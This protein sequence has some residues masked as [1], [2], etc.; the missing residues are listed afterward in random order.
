MSNP[1]KQYLWRQKVHRG[2]NKHATRWKIFID[3]EDWVCPYCAHSAF[4][5][6]DPAA[7]E[8]R[9]L[10]HFANDCTQWND[11]KGE[12]LS[13]AVLK[14][15]AEKLMARQRLQR[16][17]SWRLFDLDG[18]W[19]CPYCC[20]S[21]DV[22]R[23]LGDKISDE[24][25]TRVNIHLKSCAIA[26][27]PLARE[28]AFDTLKE[29]VQRTN[30]LRGLAA[31]IRS[32]LESGNEL[33]NQH[34]GTNLWVCPYCVRVVESVRLMDSQMTFSVAPPE[35]AEHLLNECQEF[36][37]NSNLTRDAEEFKGMAQEIGEGKR[38]R[39]TVRELRE[40][41]ETT[42]ARLEDASSELDRAR[43]VQRSI[44]P[45]EMPELPGFEIAC[46]Y[47][48][49]AQLGG[50]FYT[51]IKV[52]DSHLGFLV[53]DVSGHGADAALV[54]TMTKKAFD[55]RC[56]MNTSPKQVLSM[57][58]N[59]VHGDLKGKHFVTAFYGIL[60]VSNHTLYF[61]RAGHNYPLL[62]NPSRRPSISILKS[63]GSALGFGP[64]DIFDPNCE[65]RELVLQVGDLLFVYT[66][67]LVE[68]RNKANEEFELPNVCDVL[69]Q[70]SGATLDELLQAIME[71]ATQHQEGQT[72]EDDIALM[73]IRYT[74]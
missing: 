68:A 21:T 49:A 14:Q 55:L 73:A 9:I 69:K 26:K 50:D 43:E 45:D 41:L 62:H 27:K 13:P 15:S 37:R 20:H 44:L 61:G 74:G 25:V 6:K 18:R 3:G 56:P 23:P 59:D 28:I 63:K 29:T 54:M 52:D 39:G 42:R 1:V 65:E 5:C 12:M 8:D 60:N 47:Q 51:F 24:M 11:G 34:D 31:S 35:M 72:Q 40:D 22:K 17:P 53:A 38:A 4:R 19:Y 33:W 58:N 32:Q 7:L 16:R 67:G 70:H 48:P 30:R 66:D 57:I 36:M 64:N 71:A 2:I 10:D 46:T